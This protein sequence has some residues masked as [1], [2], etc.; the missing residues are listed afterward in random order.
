MAQIGFTHRTR[1]SVKFLHT[2]GAE[3]TVVSRNTVATALWSVGKGWQEEPG[4]AAVLDCV[5]RY[6]SGGFGRTGDALVG[7]PGVVAA[8]VVVLVERRGAAVALRPSDHCRQRC[9]RRAWD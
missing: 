8:D 3:E 5:A 9:A 6:A 7:G 4:E 2:K 1:V